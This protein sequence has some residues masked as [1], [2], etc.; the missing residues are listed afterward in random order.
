MLFAKWREVRKGKNFDRGLENIA[1]FLSPRSQPFDTRTHTKP[2]NNL[3]IVSS[4]SIKSLF[5]SLNVY[6]CSRLCTRHRE[7]VIMTVVKDE[8]LW[9]ALRTVT[10]DCRIRYFVLWKKN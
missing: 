1:A 3:P 8:K 7:H 2:V 4:P 10:E 9:T 6:T 5:W